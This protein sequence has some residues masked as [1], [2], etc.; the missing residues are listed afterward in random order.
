MRRGRHLASKISI[1]VAMALLGLT[2]VAAGAPE[3][4]APDDAY[5]GKAAFVSREGTRLMLR[6]E[7]FRFGGANIYWLGLAEG[8]ARYPTRFEID[9]ALRTAKGMGVTVVRAHTLGISVGDPLSLEPALDQFNDKAFETIDYA[10]AAARKQGIRFIVPLTDAWRY[11]HGGKHTFTDWY[12]LP[13]DHFYT[14]SRVVAAYKRYIDHLTRHVNPLTGLAYKNDPTIMAWEIGNELE[15]VSPVPEAW[16]KDIS[17]HLKELAPSQLIAAGPYAARDGYPDVDIIDGHFNASLN[18]EQV[19][20]EA[21][22]AAQSGKAFIAGEYGSTRVN[23]ATMKA[24]AS[25][26]K[27]AGAAFWSLFAHRND[28]G[29]TQHNDGYT[30]H[31]PGD[32]AAMR[33]NVGVI[34]S[35]N[36]AMCGCPPPQVKLT[37]PVVTS[38]TKSHGENLLAWRGVA[39]AV[40]YKVRR[41]PTPDGEWTT[42]GGTDKRLVTDNETPWMDLD[43]PKDAAYY[44]VIPVNAAGVEGP[45]SKAVHVPAY[46]GS[47]D[48]PGAFEQTTPAQGAT[49]VV[50]VAPFSWTPAPEAAY[51][52]ITMSKRADMSSPAIASTGLRGTSYRAAAG[53]LAG[54]TTYYWK[55]EAVNVNG[56]T[57][58]TG[59]GGS[60]TTHAVASSPPT[61]D[62]FDSHYWDDASLRSA[63]KRNSSGGDLTVSLASA[64]TEDGMRANYTIGAGG[65]AGVIR[66]LSTP[67]NLTGHE[68]IQFWIDPDDT[69]RKLSAQ[70][71]AAGTFWEAP[72]QLSGAEPQLVKIPF[73]AFKVPDWGHPAPLDLTS[74]TQMSFYANGTTGPGE[75]TVDDIVAYK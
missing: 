20:A 55:V 22:V 32:T 10:L 41:S 57:S 7:Q 44:Q 56:S 35:F 13:E 61:I 64:A 11:Y 50:P 2:G 34:Q 37:R 47:G 52:R 45:A 74:F 59:A 27:I 25:D 31:Y 16:T 17:A 40:G 28:Y 69:G 23:E 48:S 12:G 19:S 38:T 67:L 46:T 72:I 9:D 33:T 53:S 8:P 49:G 73:S 62:D 42:I 58:A 51:Y 39:T 70:F 30:V 15:R 1:F 43:S 60:F 65:Y 24:I 3:A 6:D 66:T 71:Q 29:F 14:D 63:W 26:E 21:A 4:E 36:Q 68:G 5:R 54:S 75:F 18:A